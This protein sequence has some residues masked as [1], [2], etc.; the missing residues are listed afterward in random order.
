[1]LMQ[2]PARVLDVHVGWFLAE[3]DYYELLGLSR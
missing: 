1:V 3:G 2:K